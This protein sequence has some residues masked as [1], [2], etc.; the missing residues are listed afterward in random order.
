MALVMWT[1][2]GLASYAGGLAYIE[3]GAAFPLNGGT[4]AFLGMTWPR[5]RA[6]LSFC[7]SFTMIACIRPGAIAAKLPCFQSISS[8]AFLVVHRQVV[9]QASSLKTFLTIGNGFQEELDS[10]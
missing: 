7:F 2:A 1:V 8:T 4:L 6:L 10:R 9:P 5:P 3:L